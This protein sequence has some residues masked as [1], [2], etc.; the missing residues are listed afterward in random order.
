MEL[1]E[2]HISNARGMCIF[3]LPPGNFTL[4]MS[5][6]GFSPK[7]EKIIVRKDSALVYFL[8]RSDLQLESG[9]SERTNRHR[10]IE[11]QGNKFTASPF[12]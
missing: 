5:Y 6:L 1:A 3:Q 8:N 12:G 4:D 7:Q 10:H 2:G 11:Q 9:Y